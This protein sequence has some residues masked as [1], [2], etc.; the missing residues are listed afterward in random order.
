MEASEKSWI[1]RRPAVQREF[2]LGCEEGCVAIT[3]YRTFG[4]FMFLMVQGITKRPVVPT[5][6]KA[7]REAIE[8]ASRVG[9][10]QCSHPTYRKL[11]GDHEVNREAIWLVCRQ[12]QETEPVQPPR[13]GGHSFAT[14]LDF[15]NILDPWLPL[16]WLRRNDYRGWRGRLFKCQLQLI[17]KPGSLAFDQA[18]QPFLGK[19]RESLYHYIPAYWRDRLNLGSGY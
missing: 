17:G 16:K 8:A 1:F 15:S 2:G 3:R 19:P 14:N 10:S 12:S 5:T 11:A 4:L 13:A 9:M 6:S 18:V 7:L